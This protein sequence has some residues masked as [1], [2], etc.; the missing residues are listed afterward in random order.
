MVTIFVFV[1][2][3]TLVRLIYSSGHA[4]QDHLYADSSNINQFAIY[5]DI[6]T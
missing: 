3:R 2:A 6:Y 5:I 1:E 4:V